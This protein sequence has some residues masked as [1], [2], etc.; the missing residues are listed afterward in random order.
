MLHSLEKSKQERVW[1]S[2]S[3]KQEGASAPFL[4]GADGKAWLTVDR[5]EREVLR[6]EVTSLSFCNC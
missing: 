1:M 6:G 5:E 3:L 4:Y 2:M